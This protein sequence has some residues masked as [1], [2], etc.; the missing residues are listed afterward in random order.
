MDLRKHKTIVLVGIYSH[1]LQSLT[2]VLYD[3]TNIYNNILF[4]KIT[5]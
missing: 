5:I 4:V 3:I 2:Y 1:F